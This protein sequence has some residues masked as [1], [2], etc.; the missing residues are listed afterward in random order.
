M[1]LRMA[2]PDAAPDTAPEATNDSAEIGGQK[3]KDNPHGDFAHKFS[4][5]AAKERELVTRRK[6]MEAELAEL[7][8][9]KQSRANA[10]KNPSKYLQDAGLDFETIAKYQLEGEHE[11]SEVESL[12]E[13]LER[14]EKQMETREKADAKRQEEL[15]HQQVTHFKKQIGDFIK[16]NADSFEFLNASP[17]S[18]DTVYELMDIFYSN[19]GKLL[20]FK[21]ACEEVES[22][23][24]N[25]FKSKYAS[26]KKIKGFLNQPEAGDQKPNPFAMPEKQ[27]YREDRPSS[28]NNSLTPSQAHAKNIDEISTEERLKRAAASLRFK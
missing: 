1:D 25:E 15:Q 14:F 6:A 3:P 17:E 22:H 8:E 19:E 20:D 11:P 26:L 28:L 27:Q 23:I 2:A 24:E 9:W 16:N 10:K 13:R 21:D 7:N 4:K 18:I 5:L 12:K